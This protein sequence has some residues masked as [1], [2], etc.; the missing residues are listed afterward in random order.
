[1]SKILNTDDMLEAA[2]ECNLP[3]YD[4]FV[5]K[6]ELLATELAEALAK[7]LNIRTIGADWEGKAFAGLCAA[8]YPKT[9]KQP[10]PEVIDQGDEG[11]EWEYREQLKYYGRKS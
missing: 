7:H 3:E 11:G 2:S 4:A 9:K 8:F 1:M 5:M 6:F 10:C